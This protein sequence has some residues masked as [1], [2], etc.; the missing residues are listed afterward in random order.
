MATIT[1]LNTNDSGAGSL[2]QAVLDAAS[3]DTIV[4][5]E[6]AFPVN[7]TTIIYLETVMTVD[8]TL[9]LDA[10]ELYIDSHGR[11]RACIERFGSRASVVSEE[12]TVGPFRQR[13]DRAFLETYR[14]LKGI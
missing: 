8:K 14:I 10:G 5:D 1:V 11:R 3:G 12:R 13:G 9:T 4:F 2:R 6:T 7:D